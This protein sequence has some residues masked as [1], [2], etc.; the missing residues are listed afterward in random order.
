MPTLKRG[1]AGEPVKILQRKLNVD[2]DGQFGPATDK[3]L[4]AYQK[5]NGLSVDGIAGP[6]TFAQMGLYELVLVKKGSRG[7][8]VKAVQKALGTGADGIFGSGTQKAVKAFQKENGLTT[9]GMVG[10]ATLAA[11]GVF[12]DITEEAIKVSRAE[13]EE[14][15]VSSEAVAEVAEDAPAA[16]AV[17][18]AEASAVGGVWGKMKSWFN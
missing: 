6:D 8:T 1:L 17:E 16:E 4:R 7:A 18:V 11:L 13:P 12:S 9:D 15:A 3:A 10:P 2:A 14:I 5:A